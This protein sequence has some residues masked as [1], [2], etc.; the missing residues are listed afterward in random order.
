[1]PPD[2]ADTA[3]SGD[4]VNSNMPP[5][6][7][8]DLFSAVPVYSGKVNSVIV[9]RRNNQD[10]KERPQEV[11]YLSRH[12]PLRVHDWLTEVHFPGV[13]IATS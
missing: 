10:D 11:G 9:R 4:L 8:R 6:F 3:P 5:A 1:M 12:L 2:K 7:K 13:H